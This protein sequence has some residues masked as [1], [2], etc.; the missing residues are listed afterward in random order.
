MDSSFN[1]ARVSASAIV[2][3]LRLSQALRHSLGNIIPRFTPILSVALLL[4]L[5]PWS[6]VHAAQ[7]LATDSP[8]NGATI[9]GGGCGAC[10][11][12]APALFSLS[13]ASATNPNAASN[14][15]L[16]ATNAT[17]HAASMSAGNVTIATN[18]QNSA[19]ISAYMASLLTPLLTNPGASTHASGAAYSYQIASAAASDYLVSTTTYAASAT[20]L[21]FNVSTTGLVTAT[22]PNNLTAPQTY[23][24]TLSATNG[25][26]TGS[27][28]FNLTVNPPPPVISAGTATGKVG[29]TFTYNISA[30]NAPTGYTATGTFPPGLSLTNATTGVISGTP[31]GVATASPYTVTIGASNA[32]G[33]G[34]SQSLVITVA[35]EIT[36]TLAANATVGTAFNYSIAASNTVAGNGTISYSATGLPPGLSVSTTT[37]AITGTPTTVTGSPFTV[38]IGASNAAGAGA[39][40]SLL[41]TVGQGSQTIT[42]FTAPA[43]VAVGATASPLSATGGASLNAVTFSSGSA[44]C[45]VLGNVVTG[46]HVGPCTLNANQLGNTDYLAAGQAST[47]I[48]VTQGSQSITGFTAPASVTVGGT[49]ATAMTVTGSGASGNAV[50]FSSGNTAI[51]TVSGNLITGVSAGTCPLNADQLGNTDYLA[52]GQVSTSI[53]VGLNP[54]SITNFAIPASV[55]VGG[56]ASPI[57]ATPGAS[58]N[59]V[60]FSSGNT[61]LCTV[62]GNV[63]TGVGVGSCPIYA[64]QL[65]NATYGNAARLT[66]NIP[67]NQGSQAITAFTV[68]ASVAVGATASPISATAGASGNPVTFS[69][70]NTALCTVAS[71]V[72]TG[73]GVGSC[74]IYADEAASAN[75]TAAPRLTLNISVGQGSQTITGFTVPASLAV[76]GAT[77][78]VSGTVASGLTISYSSTTPTTC[79]ITGTT[80]RGLATGT[81]TIAANQA[82]NANYTAA[83]Q[84]TQNISIGIGSQTLSFG[85]A[86]TVVVGGTGTVSATATSGLAVTY[87]STTAGVCTVSGSTVTGVGVGT[88]TI[89]ANQAGNANYTAAAQVTQNIVIG[90]GSQTISFATAPAIAV[91][92]TGTVSATATSGLAVAYSTASA[93]CSVNAS[94]GLVT[95]I[96]AGTCTIAANQAG[97]ANYSAA[98]Q[99]TQNVTISNL[100]PSVTAAS[101]TTT[102]NTA[103]T[104]DLAASITGTG[105]TGINVSTVAL[106][107]TTSV[108]G[109]KVTYTPAKDYFGTDTFSYVAYGTVGVSPT[110]ATVTVTITGRPDPLQDARVT[111]LVN[112]QTAAVKRFGRAQ[113]FNFQQRLESRHHAVYNNV[114]SPVTAPDVPSG[115]PAPAGDAQSGQG[116]GYFNSWQPG[117]AVAYTNDPNTLLHAPDRLSDVPGAASDPMSMMLANVV[118]GALTSSSLN[119]ATVSNAAGAMQ[120][121]SFSR[122]EVWAAGNLRFGTRSQA[123]VDT[124]FSTDG[125]SVGVDKRLDRKL[126]VG[127]G[128]GYARDKSS[129]GTDG[130]NSTSSGNSVAGYASYQMD[131]GSFIDALLG[132]GKVSFDTNRYVAS[133]NDFARATRKGDQIFGSFSFGYEYRKEGLL[134]SPYGRYDVSFDRLDAG[135]ETGAGANAL[136]YASQSSRNSQIALGLR[137]QSVHQASFG[138]VQPRARIE[139][140]RGIEN[141]GQTSIAYADLLGTQYT[142]AA[143]TLNTNSIVA[144]LGSDFLLSDTLKLAL[145]YQRLR[146]LGRENYQS[147]NF[148]LTKELE[149]KNDFEAL[150]TESYSSS[151]SH[152]TGLMVAAG[153]AFEDNASR[154]SEPSD[155]LSDIIY[156][157]TVSK[158]KSIVMSPHTKLTLSGFLDMEKFHT[159]TGLGHISGGGQAEYLYRASGEF[160][161]PTYGIFARFT[162]DNYESTLRDGSRRSAG[163]T[164]RKPV[165]DRI[166]LFGALAD[167][168]RTGRSDVFNTHDVSVRTN[169]D[170]ALAANKT[171]YLTGEYRKG[172][173][174]S[175]GRP[176]L[177]ILD[178]ATVFVHDDAFDALGFHAYRMKGKTSVLTLGYN[179]AFGAKDSIDLSY[180]W[181]HSVPDKTP[182]FPTTSTS[183]T[184]K[185]LSISYLMAF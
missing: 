11:G 161:S 134:W 133:V 76:G 92:G 145:D 81:C 10:H 122:L 77:G 25:A 16:V 88:C 72:I 185:Q 44:T 99:M 160:G 149:G 138:I 130:T 151:I 89:A 172:D 113:I 45:T 66:L 43:S 83:P 100:P 119:L 37:G 32:G 118:K 129:I 15:G 167:N 23:S 183:Y 33:T 150:L 181:V 18:A 3:R 131:S 69:S 125:I 132:Y 135:T 95:G 97:N 155:K 13:N 1:A 165:T 52:A 85:A 27:A 65:G 170:Y 179:L 62:S 180:R 22:L 136:S 141:S 71:N 53:I 127:M 171:I 6:A 39:T 184:D 182:S 61:A 120:E 2:K 174:I 50:T 116:R 157:L 21:T 75:Y 80:V 78:T 64:D 115:T 7:H 178:I 56:T 4:G 177:K 49:T 14:R 86:P 57:S 42:G 74:P 112:I 34:T 94:S 51:C 173:I 124:V 142:L 156:S 38:T 147:I 140:Q 128:M 9:Y 24:V 63:V 104:L 169:L 41:I 123:G 102:L 103:A 20:G 105:V 109:T 82:G 154:A 114:V 60:T 159:Y 126:T 93:T 29:T 96:S 146:S 48:T 110:A 176:S 46:V 106:H 58:L 108:S 28:T 117:T 70:G 148:R 175:S 19:D 79:S 35:P 68:P 8:A 55:V 26:L 139:Y 153:Y 168:V 121:D 12:A 158:A 40:K 91:G 90:I 5:M 87:S 137:A 30:T 143:T 47:S 107:G 67:V 36:S 164:L 163:V 84:V 98:A 17:T 101:M 59:T 31:T 111:G 166:H 162:A 152:P 144:G 54:Q 73:V